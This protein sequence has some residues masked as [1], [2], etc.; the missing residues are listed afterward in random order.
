MEHI[1]GC[2]SGDSLC[3]LHCSASFSVRI[4]SKELQIVHN[5]IEWP[6][7]WKKK[8]HQKNGSIIWKGGLLSEWKWLKGPQGA[9]YKN[10][11]AMSYVIFWILSALWQFSIKTLPLFHQN[12]RVLLNRNIWGWMMPQGT[13]LPKTFCDVSLEVPPQPQYLRNNKRNQQCFSESTERILYTYYLRWTRDGQV[14]HEWNV[15]DLINALFHFAEYLRSAT[16]AR[17]CL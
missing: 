7:L 5:W 16:W 12:M 11:L 9:E 10:I 6:L 4:Y 3:Q 17:I 15:A 1:L 2:L 8:K 13:S 14:P